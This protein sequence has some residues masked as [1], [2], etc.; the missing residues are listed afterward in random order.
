MSLKDRFR[1]IYFEESVGYNP[2]PPVIPT[3][4]PIT[5]SPVTTPEVPPVDGAVSCGTE[6]CNTLNIP[7]AEL[8]TILATICP[9]KADEIVSSLLAYQTS[10]PV[11]SSVVD[12]VIDA[13]LPPV[14]TAPATAGFA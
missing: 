11:N 10:G 13:T 1:K 14:A 2:L 3:P 7:E 6:G 4:A 9:E 5:T 12:Q 8:R